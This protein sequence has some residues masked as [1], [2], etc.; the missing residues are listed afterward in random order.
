MNSYLK[1]LQ[2][3][4]GEYANIATD[5]SSLNE[6]ARVYVRYSSLISQ[7][8]KTYDLSDFAKQLNTSTGRLSILSQTWSSLATTIGVAFTK[9]GAYL[10]GF[11]IPLIK[12]LEVYIQ[13]T[14]VKIQNLLNRI[15]AFFNIDLDLG[16]DEALNANSN[17]LSGDNGLDKVNKDLGDTSD[18]L[19]EVE[20]NAKK[21]KGSL[22]GFDRVNNVSTNKDEGS[23]GSDFD[24]SILMNSALDSLDEYA[25]EAENYFDKLDKNLTDTLDKI[26]NKMKEIIG[27]ENITKVNKFFGN[28]KDKIEQ[29]FRVLLGKQ[30]LDD[31]VFM[32]SEEGIWADILRF[33]DD[34]PQ[35]VKRAIEM[36]KQL[37]DILTTNRNKG[38]AYSLDT[39]V[40][41]NSGSAWGNILSII[42]SLKEIFIELSKVL[43]TF[44]KEEALPWLLEKLGQLAEWVKENKDNIIDILKQVAGFTWDSFKLFVDLVGK[45]ID[46]VVKNPGAVV[47]FFTALLG[48][49]VV[50]WFTSV[51]ASIGMALVG[52]EGF[53]KLLSGTALGKLLGVGATTGGGAA[54]GG[55]LAGISANAGPIALVIAL[56][57]GLIVVIKDLWDTSESFRESIKNIWEDI[58]ESF[59]GAFESIKEAFNNI[60]V[61][62]EN[63]YDSYE[64]SGLKQILEY[65]II[66]LIK[67][68]ADGLIFVVDLVGS[69]ISAIGNL[70]ADIINIVSGII[71]ILAGLGDIIVG[72]FTGDLEKIKEGLGKIGL[73]I[74]EIFSGIIQGFIDLLKGLGDVV[75][76][77]GNFLLSG[78]LDGFKSG[79]DSFMS[80]I[81][82][83]FDRIIQGVKDKLG[84]HSPST[85]FA[86]IGVNIV[87]GLLKGI[88]NTWDTLSS[89]V[90]DLCSGLVN[91]IKNS[92][93]TGWD[94]ITTWVDNQKSALST[95]WENTKAS[96]SNGWNN[97]TSRVYAGTARRITTHASGGSIA[98]GQ[99]FIANEN[100]T[101]ELIGNITG[102]KKTNV[103][104]NNMIIEAMKAGVFE[105]VY[106]AN[107]EIANQTRG[108]NMNSGNAN[109]KIEGFGLIDQSTLRELARMLAPYL[110]SN[111]KNI[112]DVNFTI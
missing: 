62:F 57:V 8:T 61:A 76:D 11:L 51:A 42:E 31:L 66:T 110:N 102:G 69:L 5:F 18:K 41:L 33:L 2:K 19:E 49:K 14:L 99:L 37:F 32:N 93:K 81:R 63:A 91:G 52:L 92:I 109:I 107:A 106:N 89:K 29:A 77:I 103:A 60:K 15:G 20:E 6:E 3:Q 12:K 26:K 13:G 43:G 55:I 10:A 40:E 84:I 47:G 21:A 85:V 54:S 50:S 108:N 53:N 74:V 46:F 7:F 80:S 39:V 65:V 45:L 59:S 88:T 72:I 64:S 4:G 112:A 36:V 105:A 104:N 94:N 22:Q 83:F 82:N 24:Y 67:M 101:P 23:S 48:L 28:I 34:I 56:I 79:F 44:I 86:D 27:E 73:G 1:N 35:K 100:G 75:F 111:S 68:L 9:V 98:G 90:S 70:L 95:G 58:K 16:L 71:D 38:E 78:L 30:T 96:V 25:K 97:L 87:Q 17:W